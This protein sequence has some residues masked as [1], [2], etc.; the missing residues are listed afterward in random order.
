MPSL[1]HA[2][3]AAAVVVGG[4]EALREL[5]AEPAGV[6]ARVL[7]DGVGLE[8]MA[9]RLV[10]QHAAEAV[11]HHHGQ[12]A[13][14]RV[15]GVEQREGAARGPVRHRLGIVLEQLPAGV[16]AARVAAGLHAAVATR[17]NLGAETHAG[18]VVRRGK[19]VGSEH[20]DLA[21]RLRVSDPRLRNLGAGGARPL[22]AGT[23]EVG[24]ARG[25][26]VVGAGG[27]GVLRHRLGRAERRGVAG[28]AAHGLGDR[29][30][31]AQQVLLGQAVHVPVVGR[32]ALHDPHAC[33][34][35]AAALWA[36]DASVVEREREASPRF[37]VEL[38]HVP[39][40]RQRAIEDAGGQLGIDQRQLSRSSTRATICSAISMIR[41]CPRASG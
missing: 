6:H 32:V 21:A 36:L 5:V 1:P 25:L 13:G 9:H 4:H 30:G 31:H 38:G 41:S 23:Q 15:H 20:L 28:V 24:L 17:H 10:Q 26:H 19:A 40:A 29:S 11:P 16:A 22:V 33:A 14:G 27:H 35:L 12:A 7:L 18:A 8:P 34:A 37:G 39:A 3:A 2:F